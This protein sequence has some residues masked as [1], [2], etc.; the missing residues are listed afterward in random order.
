MARCAGTSLWA[1]TVLLASLLHPSL[2]GKL[3]K[4]ALAA[5]ALGGGGGGI[6]PLP[7]PIPIEEKEYYPVHYAVPVP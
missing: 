6:I 7:L 5:A 4:V 2:Q 1:I 3:L